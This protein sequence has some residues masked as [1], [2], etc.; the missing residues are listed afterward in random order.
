MSTPRELI[1]PGALFVCPT[2]LG[3]EYFEILDIVP[4]TVEGEGADDTVQDI[5]L[6]EMGT[7]AFLQR[8]G[9]LPVSVFAHMTYVGTVR[10]VEENLR[11]PQPGFLYTY[12]AVIPADDVQGWEEER[13]LA[14]AEVHAIDPDGTVIAHVSWGDYLT[15]WFES[16][17]PAERAG[18]TFVGTTTRPRWENAL[19]PVASEPAAS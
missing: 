5:A 17:T 11:H 9:A 7:P 10:P 1:K 19:G 12:E 2:M 14:V 4:G 16:F 18:W 3:P 6:L 8:P 15:P 13:H